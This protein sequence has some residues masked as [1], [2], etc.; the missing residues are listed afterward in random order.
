VLALALVVL[1][2]ESAGAADPLVITR[3]RFFR[4]GPL[5]VFDAVVENR[6]SQSLAQLEVTAEFLSFF[7]ELVR[8]EHAGLQPAVLGPAHRGAL[9]VAT[10]WDDAI[11]KVRL[12]F[13]WWLEGQPFQS[14]PEEEPLIWR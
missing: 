11:R 5:L 10:P 13:T 9:R 4:Q 1:A 7:D 2:A 3:H 12:R 14:R 8:V 6:S